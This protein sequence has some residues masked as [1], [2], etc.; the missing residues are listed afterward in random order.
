MSTLWT[1]SDIETAT[2]GVA[3]HPFEADGLSIDTRT[4]VPGDLFIALK[5]ARDGHDFLAAAF[6]GGAAGAL[7]THRPEGLADDFPLVLV[8][9][10]QA[11]LEALG[12][13]GRTRTQAKVLGITGSV[14]KTSTK[15]MLRTVLERQGRVHVPEASYNNQWGVPL[16]LARMP[17]ETDY[18]VIEIGMNNPGEIA[19]LSRMSDLDVALITTVAPAH[20]AAFES[21]EGIA[22]EKASI[23]EGLRAGGRAIVNADIETT[24]ILVEAAKAAGAEAIFFG[25]TG[26]DWRLTDLRLSDAATVLQ[27]EHGG[28]DWLFKLSVPGPHFAM[29]ALG[30]LAAVEALGADAG[31][32]AQDLARWQ[33]YEGRGTRETLILDDAEEG[34]SFDL[35]D[36]AFNAN[37]ASVEAG[38]AVLAAA[39]PRDG[40]GR[41]GRGRRI[42]ILGDM[43]ELGQTEEALHR[44]IAALPSV[45][46]IDLI[47]CVGPLMKALHAT[48]PEV[49][50]GRWCETS[51]ELATV[52]RT[53][54]DAGDVVLVKGSKSIKLPRVVDALRKLGHPGPQNEER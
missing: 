37:P 52:A 40:I 30:A 26:R 44:D 22:R 38:L 18:A 41:I 35:I 25:E 9:D 10:V 49:K 23:F 29:N 20:L 13:A 48:L 46:Q 42:A 21:V 7:V 32:A 11:A 3:S 45:A 47:H 43:L 4:L 50:R 36:D 19:P 27:A 31:R 8:E 15:E 14:G 28:E 54:V 39:S 17:V 2:G 53:L 12:R 51:E 1:S 33:P 16:T 6:E 24:P 5:V 34:L